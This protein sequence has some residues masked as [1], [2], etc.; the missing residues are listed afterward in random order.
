MQILDID[1]KNTFFQLVRFT[2]VGLTGVLTD[3][4]VFNLLVK[5]TDTIKGNGLIPIN[6]TSFAVGVIVTFLLNKRWTFHDPS[7][8]DH[9]RKFVL[10]LSVAVFGAIINT[11]LVRFLSTDVTP[12][13]SVS[14]HG[15]LNICK[16]IAT[17]ASGIWNFLGYKN[18]V[19]KK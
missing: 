19:F 17:I 15:W 5:L 6:I 18:F 1:Y 14:I 7:S 13:F 3:F 2:L 10:F 11:A 4:V 16:G 12:L 8:Y 9:H